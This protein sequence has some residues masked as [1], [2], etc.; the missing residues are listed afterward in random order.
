MK[1]ITM[2]SVACIVMGL[3]NQCTQRPAIMFHEEVVCVKAE[4]LIE[5]EAVVP[6]HCSGILSSRCM[7]K[8]SFKTGGIISAIYVEPGQKVRKG[9][10][11]ASL[12]MTEIASQADQA[13]L[14]LEKAER[15]L[16]RVKNLYRDTVATLEQLQDV[17]LAH[18]IAERNHNIAAF[19]QQYSKITAPSDGLIIAT[20]AET[21]ELTGPGTPVL[22]FSE[23]G[24]DEWIVEAGLADKDIVKVR[25]GDKAVVVFDAY[26]GK[27]ISAYV[28]QL[29]ETAD[30]H[31]GTFEVELTVEPG[32]ERMI[33]GLVAVVDI[34]TEHNQV[35]TLIPPEAIT[36]AGGSKGYVYVVEKADTTAKRI[37]VTIAYLD[38]QYVAVEEPINKMGLV[39]TEGAAHLENGSKVIL[40]NY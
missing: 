34:E 36:G 8:M 14:A 26:P 1:T 30:P 11:L 35:V 15:D 37:P 9:Q 10:L 23:L 31:T 33:N 13:R 12:E 2:I 16:S 24:R 19:N 5:T 25:K 6:I 28:S 22:V 3:F 39:I 32:N 40:G 18:E 21:H 29:S 17:T 7:I 38:N 27:K 20:L 4:K